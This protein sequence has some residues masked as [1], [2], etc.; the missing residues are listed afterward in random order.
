MPKIKTIVNNSYSRVRD[1]KVIDSI[2]CL[3]RDMEKKTERNRGAFD[4]KISI[5]EDEDPAFGS[6]SFFF[7]DEKKVRDRRREFFKM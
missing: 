3:N 7:S 2:S 6:L 5:R 1:E 4:P